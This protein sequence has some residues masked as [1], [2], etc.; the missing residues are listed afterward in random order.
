[1]VACKSNAS[2]AAMTGP[3]QAASTSASAPEAAAAPRPSH[4]G[5]VKPHAPGEAVVKLSATDLDDAAIPA[6]VTE[7]R[8]AL[9]KVDFG[10]PGP[11]KIT[12]YPAPLELGMR[13]YASWLGHSKDGSQA[14]ACGS[15]APLQA[16]KGAEKGNVCFVNDGKTT[17]RLS[18]TDGADGKFV[19]GPEFGA[20]IQSL[21]SG[22]SVDLAHKKQAD[23]SD[24]LLPPDVTTTWPYASDIALDVTVVS[25]GEEAG[26]VLKLGGSYHKE[27]PVHPLTLAVKS[28]PGGGVLL[29]G[30]SW[31]AIL[32][33]PSNDGLTLFG[34][35]ACMEWCTEI[36][37]KRMRYDE[38][39]SLVY[40][41]TGFRHHQ[42]KEYAASR[43][44][45]LKATIANPRAKLPPYN[46]ACAYALLNE[47]ENAAKALKLAIAVGGDS[48]KARAKKDADFK[49]VLAAPWF[50]ALTN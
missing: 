35:F 29:W 38:I 49:A 8:A 40:N 19:V 34:H 50:V 12:G 4:S 32:P 41:D 14:I 13:D 31:N 5:V 39:A 2:P 43:D 18:V 16:D 1:M 30:G 42:K 22:T 3:T 44:L 28:A 45:F 27:A 47:G 25:G 26:T 21:K 9:P 23:G 48:V 33:S 24:T 20:A 37:I 6:A 7:A 36:V 11:L 17:K 15:M 46:L 10:A